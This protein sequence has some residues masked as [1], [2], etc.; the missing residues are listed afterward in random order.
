MVMQVALN[1]TAL[2]SPLTGLGQY[3]QQLAL[4]L[5]KNNDVELDFF[6]GN[7]WNKQLRNEPIKNINQIKNLVKRWVPQPYAINRWYQQRG[8][9]SREHLQKGGIYHEPN[10]LAFKCPLPLV[11]TVHDL[12]WVRFPHTHPPARVKAMNTYM[13]HGLDTASTIITDSEFVK[14]EVQNTFGIAPERI[15]SIG[16]GV[17]DIFSPMS[18]TQ[19][20][21]VLLP[22]ELVHGQY[23]LAVGTLEP[24]KNLASALLAYMQLPA[25]V[26][27]HVPLVLVGMKGWQT[28]ELEAQM[29]PLIANGEI[30][31]L[32]YLPRTDLAKIVA[33][34]LALVY[35]SL[36]EGFGLPPLEAMSCGVPVIASDVSSLPEVVGDAGILVQPTDNYAIAQAIQ[37]LVDSPETRQRFSAQSLLRSQLFGWDKCVRQT[38]AVYKKAA[39][40]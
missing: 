40:A 13:Q 6:Y 25:S 15:Q 38:L 17:E 21:D 3:T 27:R 23:I 11:L 36:Y 30:K 5:A 18:S 16:L 9:N 28:S 33:G 1:A 31:V 14:T 29:I 10:F 20:Q 8:F 35:P 12:S 4:G 2:L 37:L 19:T 32:G 24:R 26:R 34:A 39:A 22:L 7:N